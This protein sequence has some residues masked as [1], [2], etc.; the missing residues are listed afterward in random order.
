ML[1]FLRDKL[2]GDFWEKICNYCYR[3]RY[4][5]FHLTP[6]PAAYKGDGGIEG[7][8]NHG[9]VYQ[10]YCPEKNFSDNELYENQRDKVSKDIKKLLKNG[11]ILKKIG[12][13]IIKEWHF[14]TPYYKDRRIIEHCHKKE[15]EVLKEIRKN[16][17]DYISSDFK[18]Y[19]KDCDEFV[20]EIFRYVKINSDLK[21][22]FEL[23]ESQDIDLL[24]CPSMQRENIVRKV[25]KIDSTGREDIC[26]KMVKKFT[27]EYLEWVML[28]D[29]I[30]RKS[31]ELY[32]RI[33]KI[34]EAYKNDMEFKCLL[35]ASSG[36]ANF[37][38]F[39]EIIDEFE[40]LLLNELGEI[41]DK[42]SII[43]MKLEIVSSWLA[44]CPLEF[45]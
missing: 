35:A 38:T 23:D 45:L 36:E 27:K 17:L 3:Q 7:F 41:V 10:C 37:K 25:K 5:E 21:L 28:K 19:I 14:V 31:P 29:I 4:Q 30:N 12:V 34:E 44:D 20:H 18:I 16:N 40:K 1:E 32:E 6:I 24:N 39:K 13:G 33:I 9:V 2:N 43:Q 22:S 42:T 26:D 8:T 15:E 11:D